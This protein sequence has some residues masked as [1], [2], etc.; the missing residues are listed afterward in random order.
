[1]S[2][3]QPFDINI[4]AVMAFREIGRGREAME[5]FA[6]V[7]SMPPPI[8]NTSYN[9]IIDMLHEAYENSAIESKKR[10]EKHLF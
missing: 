2:Y 10:A 9:N 7:M 6:A 3:A 4:R 5:T 1:M 8:Q